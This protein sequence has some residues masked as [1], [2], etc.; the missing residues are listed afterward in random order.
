MNHPEITDAELNTRQRAEVAR[1]I[2][3]LA[4]QLRST[5]DRVERYSTQLTNSDREAAAVAADALN[6]FEQMNVGPI[7]WGIVRELGHT[8]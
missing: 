5:A 4:D 7:V 6:D 8:T 2:G 1:Q 3:R